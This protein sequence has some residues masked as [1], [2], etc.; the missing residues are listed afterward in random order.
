VLEKASLPPLSSEEESAPLSSPG[1]PP[2]PTLSMAHDSQ[3]PLSSPPMGQADEDGDVEQEIKV[4]H[5]N[6]Y[7]VTGSQW[8]VSRSYI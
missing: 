3:E 6:Q 7:A 1:L 2:M 4:S 5:T 8:C